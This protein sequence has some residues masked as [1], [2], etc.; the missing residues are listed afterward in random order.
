MTKDRGPIALDSDGVSLDYSTAYARGWHRAFGELPVLHDA[1]AY[2]PM[3]RWGVPRLTGAALERLR[4]AC[5][6]QRQIAP[7]CRFPLTQRDGVDFEAGRAGWQPLL[8]GQSNDG[9]WVKNV[10]APTTCFQ[11][12]TL[13]E[14]PQSP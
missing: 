11:L 6:R 3:E 1:Q 7:G 13:L 8:V 5:W 10:S 14:I 9:A 4:S 12:T 2:W